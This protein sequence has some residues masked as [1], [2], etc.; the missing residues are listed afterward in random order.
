MDYCGITEKKRIRQKHLEMLHEKLLQQCQSL[1]VI[2]FN[3]GR[4]DLNAIKQFVLPYLKKNSP[5]G[6]KFVVKRNNNCMCV[7][8]DLVYF[9]D[10]TNY[11]APS[12]SYTHFL[13]ASQC[14]VQK[15]HF[16]YKWMDSFEKLEAT[17]LPPHQGFYSELRGRNITE[18]EY[19]DCQKIWEEENMQS[20]KDYLEWYN[21]LDVELF[22]E[23]LEKIMEFWKAR[24]IQPFKQAISIPGV[25][26]R[27]LFGT[28]T[29]PCMYFSFPGEKD[30]DQ[31][32][33]YKDNLV[34]GDQA[35]SFTNTIGLEKLREK[36]CC[37]IVRYD[38]NALYHSCMMKPHTTGSYVRRCTENNFAAESPF[39]SKLSLQ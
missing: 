27:Y 32:K 9:L 31:V 35:S 37:K 11:I 13:N 10:V 7:N 12:F 17:E 5:T 21:N 33:L 4:Y 28:V 14:T 26:L 20:M 23:A 15:S 34:G 16:P 8:T 29:D 22:I 39:P 38:A 36:E 1:P 2:G 30:K 25:T 6:I 3:S 19:A 18:E 24:R